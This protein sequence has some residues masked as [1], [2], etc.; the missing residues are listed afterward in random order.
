MLRPLSAFLFL[1]FLSS[2]HSATAQPSDALH[3]GPAAYRQQ[4]LRG[5]EHRRLVRELLAYEIQ[6]IRPLVSTEVLL[7][8][9]GYVYVLTNRAT[10]A[11]ITGG[12]FT[13]TYYDAQNQPLATTTGPFGPMAPGGSR[14][15]FVSFPRPADTTRA[16]LVVSSV[17]AE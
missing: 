6:H 10:L 4:S 7:R 17:Q 13:L 1:L 16:E 15:H 9:D 5:A 8:P 11:A 3:E 12:S 14:N 2:S